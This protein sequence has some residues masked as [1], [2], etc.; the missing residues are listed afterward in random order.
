M[1]MKATKL[2][3][4]LHRRPAAVA[5][6]DHRD[7]I[8]DA[9]IILGTRVQNLDHEPLIGMSVTHVGPPHVPTVLT[10]P[11][12]GNFSNKAA[13][14]EAYSIGIMGESKWRRRE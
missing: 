8:D 3:I 9:T 4:A 6:I 13:S 5:N 2:G 10:D 11:G 7:T 14:A 1:R 12:S